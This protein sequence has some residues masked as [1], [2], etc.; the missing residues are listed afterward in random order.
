MYKSLSKSGLRSQNKWLLK[1][2]KNEMQKVRHAQIVGKDFLGV[3]EFWEGGIIS[4]EKWEK[5][6]NEYVKPT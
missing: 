3:E 2:K 1:L 4:K 6:R 5:A